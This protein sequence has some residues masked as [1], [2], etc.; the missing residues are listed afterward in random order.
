[1]R[2]DDLAARIKKGVTKKFD[3]LVGAVAGNDVLWINAE[4]RGEGVAQVK[5]AAVGVQLDRTKMT[6]HRGDRFR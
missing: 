6:L 3:D 2:G 5:C 1:M 4:V